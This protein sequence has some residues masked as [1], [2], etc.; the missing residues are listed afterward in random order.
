MGA[1]TALLCAVWVSTAARTDGKGGR[2]GSWPADGFAGCV[3]HPE[4]YR[5]RA[6]TPVKVLT[7][8]EFTL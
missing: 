3:K 4:F 2:F 5:V 7:P 1:A 8:L 6:T